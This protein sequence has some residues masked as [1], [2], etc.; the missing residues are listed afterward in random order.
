MN[1]HSTAPLRPPSAVTGFSAS[2]AGVGAPVQ[3]L[4]RLQIM[5]ADEWEEFIL[6]WVD[7]LRQDQTYTEVHGSGGGGD[8]GCDIIGFKGAIGPHTPWDNYQ[9]KHY[10]KPLSVADVVGE[11]GKLSYYVAQGQFR[12][13]D[14]YFFVAPKG[15][16]TDLLKCLQAGTL[17]QQLINRWDAECRNKI[18]S[19]QPVELTPAIKAAYLAGWL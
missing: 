4:R 12:L 18:T 1:H 16:S 8:M 15:P 10:N 2:R 7:A 6:E 11:L 5:E 14:A 19:T 9:C 13:P 17:K 3:P